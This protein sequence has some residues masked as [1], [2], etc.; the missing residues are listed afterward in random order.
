MAV[1]GG[2][3]ERRAMESS[4]A[5]AWELA[6][7]ERAFGRA[8]RARR[9]ASLTRRVLRR[10]LAC[11]QLAV[12]DQRRP[13]ASAS[14]RE[15]PLSSITGTLEPNRAAEFD[16]AF[17]PVDSARRRWTAV[18]LAEQR[19]VALPPISVTAVCDGYAIRDGHHRV[20]VAHTRGAVTISARIA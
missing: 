15:I 11:A 1:A 20:S 9:R 7:A 3:C 12:R 17:R 4:R 5:S 18:W 19:G 13:V 14:V 6:A 16:A 8:L 10:C 2:G